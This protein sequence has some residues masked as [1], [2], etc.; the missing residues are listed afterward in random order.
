[1]KETDDMSLF[2]FSCSALN[3]VN[4]GMQMTA[5]EGGTHRETHK[6]QRYRTWLWDESSTHQTQVFA[7]QCGE[8][9]NPEKQGHSQLNLWLATRA[10]ENRL[11]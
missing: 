9:K 10:E 8:K 1:M 6:Q 4:T 7:H 2:V 5:D 11:S 3:W